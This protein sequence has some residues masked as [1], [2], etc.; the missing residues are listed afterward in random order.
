MSRERERIAKKREKNPV[1]ECNKV[2]AKFYPDLF[3]AF[4]KAKDPRNTSYT[5]YSC[6]DMLGTIYYKGI[7]G[8]SSM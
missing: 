1:V 8:I 5:D 3:T 2:Q 6:R 7:V 4:S